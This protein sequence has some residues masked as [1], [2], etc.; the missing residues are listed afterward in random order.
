MKNC[1]ECGICGYRG[2]NIRKHVESIHGLSKSEYEKNHGPTLCEESRLKYSRCGK[3]NAK[4]FPRFKDLSPEKQKEFRKKV[5]EG[6]KKNVKDIQ[7][8]S[9]HMRRWNK[10]KEGRQVASETAKR[11]SK[12]KE[13]L[14]ARTENLKRWRE[15]N[16]EEFEE[17]CLKPLI[18]SFRS[19]AEK[20][21]NVYLKERF[22]N[23][24]WSAQIKS[25]L[26][27][28]NKTRRKQID[29]LNK[30]DR[31]IVEFDGPHHFW[32]EEQAEKKG[33]SL[34]RLQIRKNDSALEEYC[35]KNGFLLI[36]LSWSC[37]NQKNKKIKQ[38]PMKE[39]DLAI[40]EWLQQSAERKQVGQVL[41]FG[42]EFKENG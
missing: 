22:D 30:Q 39:V 2:K 27:V 32:T 41:K 33:L 42:L 1:V 6:A 29:F 20:Y 9:E 31:I 16:R 3:E 26:F 7:R 10:S 36:R 28:A 8:R 24:K 40:K 35:L 14:A 17:K 4:H 23:F 18:N 25:D 13:I 38:K 21:L 11:T 34:R 15:N 12:R 19:N 37:Y 5:S